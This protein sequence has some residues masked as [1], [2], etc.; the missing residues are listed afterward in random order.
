[1]THLHQVYT[2][3]LAGRASAAQLPSS[4][5]WD[6]SQP[7]DLSQPLLLAAYTASLWSLSF[8]LV[9]VS[10]ALELNLE[11]CARQATVCH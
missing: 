10:M 4:T 3:I 9:G 7:Q 5:S 8:L 1:M 11:P 6:V 2:E